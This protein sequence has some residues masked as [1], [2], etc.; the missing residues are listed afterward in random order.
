MSEREI[1]SPF[2]VK[3]VIG[4]PSEDEWVHQK[5]AESK[6]PSLIVNEY[7]NRESLLLAGLAE[8]QDPY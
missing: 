5:H 3:T 1:S 8:R 2:F 4:V 6:S 7:W